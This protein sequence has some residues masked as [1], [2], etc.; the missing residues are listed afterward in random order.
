[1]IRGQTAPDWASDAS[2]VVWSTPSKARELKGQLREF[3]NLEQSTPTQ[4]LL[5]RKIYKAFDKKEVQ[6]A[7]A[8]QKIIIR[9]AG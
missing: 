9:G 4:Q 3:S 8:Q 2:A 5:F 6:L 1:M 7:T